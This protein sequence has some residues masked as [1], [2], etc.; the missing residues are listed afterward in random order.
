MRDRRRSLTFVIQWRWAL[1][2]T[3]ST[4]SK[5]FGDAADDFLLY[6]RVSAKRQ[7]D[8]SSRIPPRYG[9]YTSQLLENFVPRCDN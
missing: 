7:D 4:G 6:R 5:V 9:N 8:R 1:V 3:G 2:T